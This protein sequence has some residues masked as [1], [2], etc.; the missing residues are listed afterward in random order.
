M[1]LITTLLFGILFATAS[2]AANDSNDSSVHE[3]VLENGMK[4]LVKP[5]R[6]APIVTSQVWYRVGSSHEPP[7]LTGISHALEHMM[8]KGTESVP[9]GEF[10]RIIASH[11]GE[12][13][14]FTGVDYTAYYQTLAADRLEISLRLEA[15]RMRN[16]LLSEE[17]FLKEIEVVKEERR[18]RTEDNPNSLTAERFRAVAYAHNSYRQPVIGWMSDLEAMTVEDLRSWYRTWY[19]PNNAILVVVGDVDPAQVVSLAQRYFGDFAAASLPS[20]KPLQE[21]PRLGK[22]TTRVAAPAQQPYLIVGFD[23]PSLSTAEDA[24]EV[25]ALDL[26][27]SIL[28]GGSSARLSR[29]LLRGQQLAVSVGASYNPFARLSTQFSFSGIPVAGVTP[30]QLKAAVLEQIARLQQEL[31]DPAE[32]ARVQTQVVASKVYEL[33]SVFSQALQLGLLESIGLG[34][35]LLDSY[36]DHLKA[37]T[38]EQVREVAKKYLVE[39]RMTVAIL[40]PLPMDEGQSRAAQGVDVH[41]R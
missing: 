24:Q 32:I 16:L 19:A 2:L 35:P 17:E 41:A 33:D 1:R 22:S 7:G 38:A 12:Q 20:L 26:L 6:R 5:D 25:W 39:E 40:D 13:N 21:P 15:D 31:A 30:A 23:V 28:D 14:A 27:S 3:V 11:G 10:S 29:E 9:A 4:V 8:F 37:V 18:L 34:W 36:L